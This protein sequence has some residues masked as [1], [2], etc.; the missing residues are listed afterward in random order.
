[1]LKFCPYYV[2]M[3]AYTTR[4]TTKSEGRVLKMDKE[5]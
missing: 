4:K 5:N 3:K 1:M 2:K